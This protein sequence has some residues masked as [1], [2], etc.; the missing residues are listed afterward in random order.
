MMLKSK[1]S[2]NEDRFY[3]VLPQSEYKNALLTSKHQ[4]GQWNI[5]TMASV[6]LK[7]YEIMN[8]RDKLNLLFWSCNYN[9]SN[10]GLILPTFATS[11]LA[12]DASTD[13]FTT[14]PYNFDMDNPSTIMLHQTS[15]DGKKKTSEVG[16]F[17]Y[18]IHLKPL[19]YYTLGSGI[20]HSI[21]PDRDAASSS[22]AVNVDWDKIPLYRRHQIMEPNAHMGPETQL[23]IVAI[24]SFKKSAF[25][26]GE[27]PDDC[28]IFLIGNAVKNKWILD[29]S[30]YIFNQ[31]IPDPWVKHHIDD[32]STGF[33]IY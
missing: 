4:V 29:N 33:N 3:A 9:S 19:E 14:D 32:Y 26:L 13:Y 23:N 17:Q 18:Y 15:T 22:S 27:T 16:S 12:L 7:L 25:Y 6:K 20:Y 28:F 24:H 21:G 2:K 10:V 30:Q 5:S 11:T 31:D 1:A 8:T